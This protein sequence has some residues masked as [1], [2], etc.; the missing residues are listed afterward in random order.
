MSRDYSHRDF[1]SKSF[2]PIAIGMGQTALAWNDLLASL[3]ALFSKVIPMSNL[4]IANTIWGNISSDRDQIK[5]LRQIAASPLIGINVPQKIRDEIEWI[6]KRALSII[7]VRNDLLHSPFVIYK[8][9]VSPLHLGAH[10]RALK[11]DK[12]RD[13]KEDMAWFYDAV[14][15]LRN[16]ADDVEDAMRNPDYTLPGRPE[17]LERPNHTPPPP[18]TPK[19]SQKPRR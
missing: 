1:K 13:V 16:H 4:L 17:W 11:Y 14:T 7:D 5:I 2:Q 6:T 15:K 10:Q 8:G 12:T 9:H 3:C 19:K 18:P